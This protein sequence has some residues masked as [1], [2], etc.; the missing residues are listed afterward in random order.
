M[1]QEEGVAGGTQC[2]TERKNKHN[3]GM[4]CDG[5]ITYVCVAVVCMCVCVSHQKTLLMHTIS[6]L[7]LLLWS[8]L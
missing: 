6:L 3:E 1:K 5:V 4:V 2:L 7:S 8:L